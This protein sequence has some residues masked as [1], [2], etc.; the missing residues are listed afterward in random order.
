MEKKKMKKSYQKKN[1]RKVMAMGKNTK[2]VKYK[3][4]IRKSENKL[5][6]RNNNMSRLA[7]QKNRRKGKNREKKRK[8]KKIKKKRMGKQNSTE[9][10]QDV[11]CLNTLV[12]VLRMNK[13]AVT[14]FLKQRKRLVSR[15]AILASKAD[16]SNKVNA[17]LTHL[18]DALGG[19]TALK[20]NSPICGGRYNSSSATEVN[21]RFLFN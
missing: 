4:K 17:S 13:D 14:N 8:G 2:E 21:I 3:S 19:S 6:K 1:K 12:Q 20:I 15:L 5:R 18:T 11:E 7:D 16:K 10:C 9:S